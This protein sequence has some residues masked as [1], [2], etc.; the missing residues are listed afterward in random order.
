[1]IAA[2]CKRERPGRRQVVRQTAAFSNGLPRTGLL[3]TGL[4]RT[5][6]PRTGLPRTGLP[7]TGRRSVAEKRCRAQFKPN[8]AN[9]RRNQWSRSRARARSAPALSRSDSP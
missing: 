9:K 6:L 3:R 8:A 1:M 7:R 2:A 5:G 4:P